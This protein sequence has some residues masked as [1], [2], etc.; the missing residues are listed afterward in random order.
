MEDTI[1]R[2]N[3]R[4]WKE[5]ST[6]IKYRVH[7]TCKGVIMARTFEG[8]NHS[9]ILNKAIDYSIKEEDGFPDVV[10]LTKDVIYL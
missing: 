10:I 4:E 3:F 5:R 9:D 2:R 6:M 8:D 1:Q 7:I